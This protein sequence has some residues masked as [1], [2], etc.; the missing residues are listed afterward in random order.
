MTPP[1]PGGADGPVNKAR[2]SS[3]RSPS[4]PRTAPCV[5]RDHLS[6]QHSGGDQGGASPTWVRAASQV[7]RAVPDGAGGAGASG[8]RRTRASSDDDSRRV[9]S[10]VKPTALTEAWWPESVRGGPPAIG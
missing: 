2:A 9:P 3:D 7:D 1:S 4:R 8:Q 6:C 5:Q 10:G